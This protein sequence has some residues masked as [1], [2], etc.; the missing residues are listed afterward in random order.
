[1]DCP[2]HHIPNAVARS[3]CMSIRVTIEPHAAL[4]TALRLAFSEE[5]LYPDNLCSALSAP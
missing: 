2:P 3:L 4:M 5:L 1:M